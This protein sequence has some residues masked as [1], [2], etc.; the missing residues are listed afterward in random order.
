MELIL[1]SDVPNLGQKGDIVKVANGYARNYLIPRGDALP[2]S[3]AA[4]HQLVEREKQAKLR[5]NRAHRE[6]QK[7]ANQL[8]RVSLTARVKVGEEDR[9]FGRITTGDISALLKE[10]GFDIEKKR[11]VLEE[12]INS[13]GIYSVEIRLH[14]EVTTRVKL[15][16]V[17]E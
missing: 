6:A 5:E 4:R 10:K 11:V 13:L 2:A 12:P 1:M 7:A 16:V 9:I 3:D 15:W 14:P 8:R 17:K